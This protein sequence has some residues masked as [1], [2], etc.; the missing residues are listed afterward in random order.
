MKITVEISEKD[1]KDV[2]RFSG[3]KKK[4]P[5]ISKFVATELMLKRRRE[6]SRKFLTGEWSVELP[7]IEKLRED[8]N[9]WQ[10]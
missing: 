8:R 4:G 10:R 1:L 5:A 7:D 3:E 9:V 2:I 6:M